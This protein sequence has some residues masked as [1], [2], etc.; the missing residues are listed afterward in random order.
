LVINAAGAADTD[1][2]QANQSPLQQA[3]KLRIEARLAAENGDF[4]TAVN[5]IQEAAR[6]TGDRQTSERATQIVEKMKPAGGASFAVNQ[7]ELMDLIISQTAP[8]ASWIDNGDEFGDM[9]FSNQGVFIGAPAALASIVLMH[10]N[11]R[12]MDA[13]E[14]ARKANHN[15]DI[16]ASS[17]LRIV[18]LPRLEAQVSRYIQQGQQVPEE[19]A[20][21]AGISRI[22]YVFVF[23]E[24]GDVAIAGP[25]GNWVYDQNGQAINAESGRPTLQLDDLVTLGRVFSQGGTGFFGCSID[26]KQNQVEKL[27]NFVNQ[28]RRQLTPAN[29]AQ[30]TKKLENDLGLQNVIIQGVP[31]DSRVASVIVEADYRMKEIGIGRRDGAPG[32][33]S[34]F[35]LLTRAERRGSSSMDALRWW[36]TVGYDA[37]QTSPDGQVF[38]LTG[39]SIRCMSENQFVNENGSRQGTGKAQRPNAEFARLFTE[40]LPELAK[41]DPVFAD[42]ENV[43]DMALVSAM[44][45]AHGLAQRAGWTPDSLVAHDGYQTASVEVPEE[46]MTAAA[47][48]V[49][50][51]RNI[52]IQVAGGVNANLIEVVRN[53]E[54]FR[55]TPQLA[56]QSTVATPVGQQNNRWW[57]DAA[58]K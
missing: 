30:F 49:Y 44:V 41:Q 29:V 10:D 27:Q 40:N 31:T 39:Q 23:P 38:E 9:T 45:H 54:A 20:N 1:S 7:Q 33:K 18:S 8:P 51:G 57:W 47:F 2:N 13:F 50:N 35:D 53:E 17:D 58:T 22:K 14:L 26:P 25:A 21:L 24:T 28:N 37:I 56:G 4:V 34:Y 48:Q 46:L 36:L 55:N 32:M 12:L 3:Q 16:H 6:T 5:R 15:A 19:L 42:L 43:F 11:S 52:V